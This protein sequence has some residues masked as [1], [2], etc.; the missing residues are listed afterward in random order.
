MCGDGDDEGGGEFD[1]LL[2]ENAQ[3]LPVWFALY[4]MM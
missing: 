4:F 2:T 3:Y 1:R